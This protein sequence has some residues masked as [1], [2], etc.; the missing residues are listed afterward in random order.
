MRSALRTT[1]DL[2]PAPELL[3]YESGSQESSR[4]EYAAQHLKEDIAF[5]ARSRREVL[6]RAEGGD[7]AYA[8]VSTRSRLTVQGKGKT[9]VLPSAETMVLKNTREGWRI[10]HIH[11]SS[12]DA[13]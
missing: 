6:S 4:D 12:G 7:A 3:V 11:W 5:L 8:W 13:D 1:Q 2:R 9:V 10:V